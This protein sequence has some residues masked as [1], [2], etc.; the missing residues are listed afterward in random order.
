MDKLEKYRDFIKKVL[1]KYYEWS[2][3]QII[4][5]YMSAITT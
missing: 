4:Q 5:N 3:M 2:L 1:N